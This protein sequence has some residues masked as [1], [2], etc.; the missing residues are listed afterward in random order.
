MGFLPKRR[1]LQE[2]QEGVKPQVESGGLVDFRAA[3]QHNH[4]YPT[5]D[6]LKLGVLDLAEEL[7]GLA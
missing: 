4:G 3:H 5:V 6:P 2:N 1:L 7:S